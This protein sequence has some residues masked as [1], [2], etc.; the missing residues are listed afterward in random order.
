VR[1]SLLLVIHMIIAKDRTVMIHLH[2]VVIV[3]APMTILKLVVP[4]IMSAH[5]KKFL[6]V[7]KYQETV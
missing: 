4:L 3:S 2:M 5:Q 1:V 6:D 7:V